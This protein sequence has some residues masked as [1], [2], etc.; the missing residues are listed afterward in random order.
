MDWFWGYLIGR[1]AALRQ[2]E[3]ERLAQMTPEQRKEYKRAKFER[4]LRWF[5]PLAVIAVPLG[6]VTAVAA[7]SAGPLFFSALIFA[8]TALGYRA[9]VKRWPWQTREAWLGLTPS[10][11]GR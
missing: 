9:R 7:K 1:S 5:R 3:R 11:I 10:L 4:K 8:M 2:I 6:I